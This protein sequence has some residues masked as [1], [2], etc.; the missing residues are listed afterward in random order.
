MSRYSTF[1]Y[2]GAKYAASSTTS[3]AWALLV[4]WDG[5]GIYDGDNE[6]L[7]MTDL[8][9]ERG[10]DYYISAGNDGFEP[11]S[12]GRA[13]ITLS[14]YDGR[15]NPYNASSPLYPNVDTGKFAQIIVRYGATTYTVFTGTIVD[16]RQT[17]LNDTV[18]ISLEDGIGW[19]SNQTAIK[20]YPIT[21]DVQAPSILNYLLQGAK[22]PSIWGTNFSIG[23]DF[24]YYHAVSGGNTWEEIRKL[25]DSELA[26]YCVRANGSLFYRSRQYAQASVLSLAQ[27]QLTKNVTIPMPWEFRK[28]IIKFNGEQVTRAGDVLLW[29]ATTE[30]VIGSGVTTQTTATFANPSLLINHFE[31]TAFSETGG[32]GTD[33]STSIVVSFDPLNTTATSAV[34]TITNSSASMAYVNVLRAYGVEFS[35]IATTGSASGAGSTTNPRGITVDL[36]WQQNPNNP[37]AMAGQMLAFF[38]ATQPFPVIEIDNRPDIQFTPDLFDLISLD[39]T[40]IGINS[41][42]RVGKIRH[43][44]TSETGQAV[45]TTFGLE[46]YLNYTGYWLF[47]S[48]AVLDTSLL[49]W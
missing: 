21:T 34:L 2:G 15:Y 23:S 39:L 6:A 9:I 38:N 11:L 43:E 18:E 14:N 12:I 26:I 7:R 33:L 32:V 25:L 41:N 3:I 29:T 30:V 16:L 27:D 22:W 20:E 46:P 37:Q 49:G 17:G 24:Y 4:D 28:N 8:S 45:K 35:Q 47:N 13:T 10:R 40:A 5:D 31:L 42:F 1:K 44:W 48:N 36:A 19:L